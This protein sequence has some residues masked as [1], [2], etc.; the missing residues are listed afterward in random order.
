MKGF[1]VIPHFRASGKGDDGFIKSEESAKW[2]PTLPWV[3]D[4][5][6]VLGDAGYHAQIPL[7]ER[8]CKLLIRGGCNVLPKGP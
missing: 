5:Q 3:V 6:L 1:F 2:T 7:D 4:E 8:I